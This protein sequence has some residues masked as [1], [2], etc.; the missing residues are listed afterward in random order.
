MGDERL[1]DVE[2]RL[3]WVIVLHPVDLRDRVGV[4]PHQEERRAG[5]GEAAPYRVEPDYVLCV[6]SVEYDSPR[7]AMTLPTVRV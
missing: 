5:L 3:G 2:P 6:D 1:G 4:S 7:P